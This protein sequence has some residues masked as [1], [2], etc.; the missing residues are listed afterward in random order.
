MK[1]IV[2]AHAI[3]LHRSLDWHALWISLKRSLVKMGRVITSIAK[4]IRVEEKPLIDK[5]LPE[6]PTTNFR[7]LHMTL[8]SIPT[9]PSPALQR[10]QKL[11]QTM[12]ETNGNDVLQQIEQDAKAWERDLEVD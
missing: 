2:E 5:A 12:G 7:C 3:T 11:P 1:G 9:Y 10:L 6:Y 4:S 8:A